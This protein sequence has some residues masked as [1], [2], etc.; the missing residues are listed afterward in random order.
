[1]LVCKAFIP[2][3]YNKPT[4]NHKDHNKLNNNVD[5]LEWATSREQNIHKRKPINNMPNARSIWRIDKNTNEK[6]EKYKSMQLAT[7]WLI[8]NNTN[9]MKPTSY[10]SHITDVCNNKKGRYTTFGYKWSYADVEEY[11]DEIWK[12]ILPEYINNSLK[13][14]VSNYGRFMYSNNKIISGYK[15][16]GY[17]KVSLNKKVYALHR[18]VGYTFIPNPE[19]K[20]VINHI[21]GNKLNNKLENLEWV[22]HKENAVHAHKTGL[23]KD[24]KKKI[25]QIDLNGNIIQ[26]FNSIAET[27][28]KLNILACSISHC[29]NDN[30]RV[31]T[32]G[33]FIFKYYN[34]NGIY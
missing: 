19:N 32:A 17:L 3:L 34:E 18:L 1:V 2:N 10:A 4:V 21:D 22:T 28:K 20:P 26:H 29:C 13:C 30:H 12:D 25:V 33:G 8:K 16:N 7:E 6:L 23:C 9:R 15:Q 27:S 14:K 11:S 24:T 5:N 31:K